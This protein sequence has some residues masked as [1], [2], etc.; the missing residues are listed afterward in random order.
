[1]AT[2]DVRHLDGTEINKIVFGDEESNWGHALVRLDENEYSR[3]NFK[4]ITKDGTEILIAHFEA[5]ALIEAIKKAQE[6]WS[7]E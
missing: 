4:I 2:L 6:L 3:K 1:M 7:E 5:P